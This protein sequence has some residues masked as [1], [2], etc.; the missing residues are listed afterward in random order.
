MYVSP[1]VAPSNTTACVEM[2]PKEEIGAVCLQA[3][4][5]L[6]EGEETV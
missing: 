3:T 4:W 6:S 2:P 5:I 1:P